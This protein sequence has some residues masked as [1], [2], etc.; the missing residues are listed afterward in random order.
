M[1]LEEQVAKFQLDSKTIGEL[2]ASQRQTYGYH[3]HIA[4]LFGSKMPPRERFFQ[5]HCRDISRGGFSFYLDGQ[6]E[7]AELVVALGCPPTLIHVAARVVN[8]KPAM[9]NGNVVFRVGC[10]FSHRIYPE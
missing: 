4:P 3:Q 7:F 10:S 5:V 2:R 9:H 1:P 8:V 6:P